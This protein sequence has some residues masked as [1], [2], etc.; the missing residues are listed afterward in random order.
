MLWAYENGITAGTSA[1][2]FSPNDTCTNGHVVT[3]LWRTNG[4]PAANGTSALAN[5]FPRDYYTNAVAWAD[6]NGLLADTGAAFSPTA[7]SPRANIVTYLYRNQSASAAQPAQPSQDQQPAQTQQ[8][9]QPAQTQQPSQT[10][11]P[12]Q[13]ASTKTLP[14]GMEITDDNIR[15]IING[16]K[17][18]FP[19]GRKWNNDDSYFSAA[20]HT[21]GYGCAGF[22]LRCSDEVFGTLPV[23]DTH[24]DFDKIKVGDMLRVN[25]DTH[26]VIVLE[27]K[28]DSVVVAEGNFNNSI[29]WGRELSRQELERGAFYAESRY[30]A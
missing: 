25:N 30:P 22:A 24:S 5:S 28:A 3:F 16:L 4:Q 7:Q 6:C 14:N 2:T 17:T 26:S 12:E 1:N 23:T 19:E 13:A 29:H 10:Q 9:S 20:L 11:Q 15:S 18:E 21:T 8:P 27:K